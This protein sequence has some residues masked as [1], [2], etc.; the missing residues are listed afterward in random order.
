MKKYIF[1]FII[2]FLSIFIYM[3]V[4]NKKMEITMN[5]EEL[6]KIHKKRLNDLTEKDIDFLLNNIGTEKNNEFREKKLIRNI[7][8]K[9]FNIDKNIINEINQEIYFENDF[10]QIIWNKKYNYVFY[11]CFHTPTKVKDLKNLYSGL[12]K[13]IKQNNIDKLVEDSSIMEIVSDEILYRYSKPP[14]LSFID[15]VY[16]YYEQRKKTN[17]K[18][19]ATIITKEQTTENYKISKNIKLLDTVYCL[20]NNS[21]PFKNQNKQTTLIHRLFNTLEDGIKWLKSIE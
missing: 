18:Y 20:K 14:Q 19:I 13:L 17:I 12:F 7:K 1:I 2:T 3:C 16:K 6:N 8:I 4:P 11:R 9:Y 21:F 5:D 15:E 10:C